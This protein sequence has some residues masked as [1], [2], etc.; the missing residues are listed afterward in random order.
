MTSERPLFDLN[1]AR[2]RAV[3]AELVIDAYD[4]LHFARFGEGVLTMT[5]IQRIRA[6]SPTSER[7][8]FRRLRAFL[9]RNGVV[10]R[11]ARPEARSES[12]H[13]LN[14]DI[15]ELEAFVEAHIDVACGVIEQYR[16][17]S[18]IAVVRIGPR[19]RAESA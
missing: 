4:L 13:E 16:Q 2:A 10:V 3:R 15:D 19:R 17:A 7:T 5:A 14:L 6:C 12:G 18:G 8:L 1:D 9:Q 11:S